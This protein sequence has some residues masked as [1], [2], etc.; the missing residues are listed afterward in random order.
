MQLGGFLIKIKLLIFIYELN[1][2]FPFIVTLH[3]G[4]ALKGWVLRTG[5]ANRILERP[6]RLTTL[7]KMYL[8]TDLIA[9]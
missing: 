7:S 3:K 6:M 1:K 2:I 5:D 8:P 9:Y 4:K